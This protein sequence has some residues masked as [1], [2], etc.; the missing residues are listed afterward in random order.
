MNQSKAFGL[1]FLFSLEAGLSYNHSPQKEKSLADNLLLVLLIVV[2]EKA[3]EVQK[4]G[5][6]IT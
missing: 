6:I 1:C 2:C 3:A 5:W 4:N